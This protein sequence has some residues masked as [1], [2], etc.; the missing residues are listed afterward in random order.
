MLFDSTGREISPPMHIAWFVLF[1]IAVGA[2]G[3]VFGWKV[4]RLLIDLLSITA[5]NGLAAIR[6]ACMGVGFV[7]PM[8]V[9]VQRRQAQWREWNEAH[10]KAY[11]PIK[12]PAPP[13]ME[14]VAQAGIERVNYFP[15]L[16]ASVP[17]GDE[18][19]V[20]RSAPAVSVKTPSVAPSDSATSVADPKLIAAY[21][22][23]NA[24][25]IVPKMLRAA[26]GKF[27]WNWPVFFLA[28]V[29]LAYRKMYGPFALVFAFTVTTAFLEEWVGRNLT[30]LNVGASAGLGVGFYRLYWK[31]YERA[32][33]EASTGQLGTAHITEALK[34][35]GG[36]SPFAGVATAVV[37]VLL[38]VIAAAAQ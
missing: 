6:L 4:A 24:S 12:A 2:A 21:V 30:G 35:A 27:A 37:L 9:L 34:A 36:V 3:A 31:R 28:P 25:T 22:G 32:V 14:S 38:A 1:V 33:A 20:Q 15:D 16:S 8:W 13:M 19:Q 26:D 7:W 5:G 29:Y 11:A 23:P 17:S 10:A 18:R